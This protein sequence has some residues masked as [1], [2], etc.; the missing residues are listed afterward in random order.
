MTEQEHPETD[1]PEPRQ[2]DGVQPTDE[3][4]TEAAA[5]LEA[6]GEGQ[7]E[8]ELEID[9][10]PGPERLHGELLD[11]LRESLNA[12]GP[13]AFD[14]WGLAF[15][16][17]LDDHEFEQQR[18]QWGIELKD[19]LDYYNRGVLLARREDYAQAIE[20]FD[21]AL[22]LNEQ[23]PDDRVSEPDL[24]F[25][26]TLAL[27]HSGDLEGAREGWKAYIDEYEHAEDLDAVKQHLTTLVDV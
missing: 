19:A 21:K 24:W 2:A 25:N 5:Q 6:E 8:L 22:E 14:R 12:E 26:R 13:A 3:E 17:S 27:E 15:L 18:E 16:H 9:T 20:C 1:A 7:V 4:S 10:G 11:M 23:Q